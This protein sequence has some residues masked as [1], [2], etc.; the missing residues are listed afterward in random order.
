MLVTAAVLFT[1]I[2]ATSQ[3]QYYTPVEDGTRLFSAMSVVGAKHQFNFGTRLTTPVLHL[4][5]ASV[6]HLDLELLG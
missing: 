2:E 3:G 6:A 5:R 4:L 1:L